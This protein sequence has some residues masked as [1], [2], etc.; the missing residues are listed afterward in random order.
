LYS[1]LDLNQFF[2]IYTTLPTRILNLRAYSISGS[3]ELKLLL[4][5]HFTKPVY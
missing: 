5:I 1:K 2:D 3:V 4:T